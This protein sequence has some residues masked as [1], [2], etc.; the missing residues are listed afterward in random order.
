M[1]KRAVLKRSSAWH[2]S[3]LMNSQEVE[4]RAHQE[5]D[6]SRGRLA[7][8]D[9]DARRHLR[10]RRRDAVEHPPR[11]GR[12]RGPD[13]LPRPPGGAL[14]PRAL[15][16][17]AWGYLVK[18]LILGVAWLAVPD[19]PQRAAT[20][21]RAAWSWAVG[22]PEAA[23]KLTRGACVR[24]AARVRI[25]RTA[26]CR[27]TSKL[28]REPDPERRGLASC[29]LLAP[30]YVSFTPRRRRGGGETRGGS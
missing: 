1:S 5:G 15:R 10:H 11:A 28:R 24:L 19:L 17:I 6:A 14:M 27:P 13:P 8:A 18:T 23:E 12:R 3:C 7:R 20:K 30:E 4:A 21:V 26:P 16:I 2:A 25:R 22:D 9:C 29:S